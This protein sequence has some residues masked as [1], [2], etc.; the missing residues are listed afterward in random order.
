MQLWL[1]GLGMPQLSPASPSMIMKKKASVKGDVLNYY[2]FKTCHQSYNLFLPHC[3]DISVI[4]KQ[5][6]AEVAVAADLL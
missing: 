2:C 4:V 5:E 1:E 3:W 6:V